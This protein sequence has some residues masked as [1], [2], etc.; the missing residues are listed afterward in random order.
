MPP[1]PEHV[2]KRIEDIEKEQIKQELNAKH[3]QE[4]HAEENRAMFAAMQTE[5]NE[6]RQEQRAFAPILE[7]INTNLGLLVE[8]KTKRD[9]IT[10]ERRKPKTPWDVLKT[11][12]IESL[13]TLVSGAI[14]AGGVWVA[15]QVLRGG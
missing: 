11:K 13:A 7:G 8:D 4:I 10:E 14:V 6:V 3:A 5:I 2:M 1:V 9:A 12:M 15:I